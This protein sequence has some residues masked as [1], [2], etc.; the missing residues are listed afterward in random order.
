[1]ENWKWWLCSFIPIAPP[2]TIPTLEKA[3]LVTKNKMLDLSL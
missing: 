3:S 1:M 2:P